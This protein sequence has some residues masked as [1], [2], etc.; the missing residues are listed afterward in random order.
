MLSWPT[1]SFGPS[2]EEF[3]AAF[4]DKA[5]MCLGA[6]G[7]TSAARQRVSGRGTI[8]CGDFRYACV[9]DGYAMTSR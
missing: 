1:N 7:M 9:P 4:T 3:A 5:C 6:M 8:R 2:G